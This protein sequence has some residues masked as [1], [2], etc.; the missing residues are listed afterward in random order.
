MK[1]A[2]KLAR[3]YRY[4]FLISADIAESKANEFYILLADKLL[5]LPL[6]I[7][8][9]LSSYPVVKIASPV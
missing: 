8:H 4:V 7:S 5:Y 2:L 9:D 6:R 3:H 1:S